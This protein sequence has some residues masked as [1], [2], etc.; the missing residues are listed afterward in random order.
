MRVDGHGAGCASQSQNPQADEH[1]L[2]S[3]LMTS[4]YVDWIAACD[5]DWVII[6]GRVAGG[7]SIERA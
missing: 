5:K 4:L 3:H 1:E 2:L 6:A 7:T